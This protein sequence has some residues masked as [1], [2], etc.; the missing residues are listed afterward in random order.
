M[1]ET[2]YYEFGAFGFEFTPKGDPYKG[3]LVTRVPE[4]EPHT[5][6]INLVSRDSCDGYARRAAELCHISEQELKEG[7]NAMCSLRHEEVDWAEEQDEDSAD[8]RDQVDIL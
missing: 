2:K 8:D 6:E 3:I 4:L 5:V 7:L 1:V